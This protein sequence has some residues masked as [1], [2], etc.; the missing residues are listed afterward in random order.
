MPGQL[1]VVGFD[2]IAL[3]EDLSL[4]LSTITQPNAELGRQSV[5]WLLQALQEGLPPPPSG[6]R[7]LAHGFRVGET[8][9]EP[10]PS[11]VS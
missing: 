3:G 10:E 11:F 7:S 2:G 4:R 9:T 8:C 5:E 6:S 1:S